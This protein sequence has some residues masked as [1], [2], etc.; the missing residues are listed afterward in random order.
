M[1]DGPNRT[2]LSS[3]SFSPQPEFFA[4]SLKRRLQTLAPEQNDNQTSPP[5]DIVDSHQK[6]IEH[7]DELLIASDFTGTR[8]QRLRKILERGLRTVDGYCVKM[9]PTYG[10]PGTTFPPSRFINEDVVRAK[11][12]SE[13]DL[14]PHFKNRR[15]MEEAPIK[16]ESLPIGNGYCNGSNHVTGCKET[17]ADPCDSDLFF[18]FDIGSPDHQESDEDHQPVINMMNGHDSSMDSNLNH[19]P[20]QSTAYG[21]TSSGLFSEPDTPSPCNA[22]ENERLEQ[23]IEGFSLHPEDWVKTQQSILASLDKSSSVTPVVSP[24]TRS[25]PA[26]QVAPAEPPPYLPTPTD[27]LPPEYTSSE[28][29]P[30]TNSPPAYTS[31]P[32]EP[33]SKDPV[34]FQLN[35]AEDEADVIE[36]TEE[37]VDGEEESTDDSPSSQSDL[38]QDTKEFKIC[39]GDHEK[40]VASSKLQSL[41]AQ[42]EKSKTLSP[43]E[44][45]SSLRSSLPHKVR[46]SANKNS[47][48]SSSPANFSFLVGSLPGSKLN[49][50]LGRSPTKSHS[51]VDMTE[52]ERNRLMSVSEFEKNRVCPVVPKPESASDSTENSNSTEN[53]ETVE[54]VEDESDRKSAFRRCSSLK[55]GKTPPCT[56]GRRKIVR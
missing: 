47:A 7:F 43:T 29:S 56:P 22:D 25:P 4:R 46:R 8:E 33:K 27:L 54:T 34:H 17:T 51:T 21:S 40:S 55:T 11:F 1:T 30:T 20:E 44:S 53:L 49:T 26:Y 50:P 28:V 14:Y 31:P 2:M 5:L 3:M 19:S 37:L 45:S 10:C 18:D 32:M 35:S 41:L 23:F 6:R 39:I 9:S 42:L 16:T 15:E 38:D 13:T 12:N 52:L 36:A 24:L 48:L